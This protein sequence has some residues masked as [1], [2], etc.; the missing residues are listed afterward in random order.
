[1]GHP[2]L[3]AGYCVLSCTLPVSQQAGYCV[4]SCTPP[5]IGQQAGHCV[6]SCSPPVISQQAKLRQPLCVDQYSC[7]ALCLC[8]SLA[9]MVC[10]YPYQQH[11]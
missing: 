2:S 8:P 4:L 6:L 5:V 11:A 9:A 1:M 7:L 10:L 3:A